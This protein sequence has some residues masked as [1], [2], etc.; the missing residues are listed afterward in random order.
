MLSAVY[1][2]ANP[3]ALISV[4]GASY[5][6]AEKYCL[7]PRLLA[8]HSR[9]LAEAEAKDGYLATKYSIIIERRQTREDGNEIDVEEFAFTRLKPILDKCEVTASNAWQLRLASC[10]ESTKTTYPHRFYQTVAMQARLP[11]ALHEDPGMWD[12]ED[13]PATSL[14][15]RVV[16]LCS[17]NLI[18][19]ITASVK[20]QCNDS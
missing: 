2:N 4:A 5:T 7:D 11:Y 20:M 16:S 13:D 17:V 6:F 8:L 15:Y 10:E 9:A 18:L 3:Y 14:S 1:S 12:S 19:L